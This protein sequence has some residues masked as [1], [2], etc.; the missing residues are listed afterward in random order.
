MFSRLWKRKCGRQN[1]FFHRRF[2]ESGDS[3]PRKFIDVWRKP[4]S[5]RM[6]D[7]YQSFDQE[8]SRPCCGKGEG[9]TTNRQKITENVPNPLRG[10]SSST[11]YTLRS[12]S[13]MLLNFCNAECSI[14]KLKVWCRF[15]D[16]VFN[17]MYFLVGMSFVYVGR[18]CYPLGRWPDRKVISVT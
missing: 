4:F 16:K 1:T 8:K 17:S 13:R 9:S 12:P 7:M 15:H 6:R 10:Q 5:S 3:P 2:I 18:L 14:C 11:W